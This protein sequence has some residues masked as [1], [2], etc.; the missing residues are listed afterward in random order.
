[1]NC[2][3][4]GKALEPNPPPFDVKGERVFCPKQMTGLP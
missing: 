4:Q 3:F 1:M 2:K